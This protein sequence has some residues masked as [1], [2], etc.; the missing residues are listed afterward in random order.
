M[1]EQALNVFR[2]SESFPLGFM[3]R[4]HSEQ[5]ITP[6]FFGIVGKLNRPQ[7]HLVQLGRVQ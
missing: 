7:S 1:G 6:V 3:I 4:G 5:H 2:N